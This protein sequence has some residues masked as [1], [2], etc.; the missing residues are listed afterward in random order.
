MDIFNTGDRVVC[1]RGN[2]DL[3]DFK[4]YTVMSS[5]YSGSMIWVI[6]EFG[7]NC[8]YSMERFIRL[9]VYTRNKVIE[10]ILS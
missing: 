9:S 2:N 5:T 6:N 7:F 4:V 8:G 3:R 1:I 10:D